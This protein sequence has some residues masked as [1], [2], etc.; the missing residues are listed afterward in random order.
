MRV[1]DNI[2]KLQLAR[3]IQCIHPCLPDTPLPQPTPGPQRD[4]PAQMGA[5]QPDDLPQVGPH[6]AVLYSQGP[7]FG[8]HPVVYGQ[9]PSGPTLG[10]RSNDTSGFVHQHSTCKACKTSLGQKAPTLLPHLPTTLSLD[11]FEQ[12]NYYVC[13]QHYY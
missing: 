8:P 6:V 3:H 2:L 11:V 7:P 9:L 4:L 5:G 1:K 13:H 10:A 12:H